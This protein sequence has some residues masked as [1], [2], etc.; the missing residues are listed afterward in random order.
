M[1]L[2]VSHSKLTPKMSQIYLIN[3][4]PTN[5][6]LDPQCVWATVG[7]FIWLGGLP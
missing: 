5:P 6:K 7:A 4:T 3:F 2:I 1:V